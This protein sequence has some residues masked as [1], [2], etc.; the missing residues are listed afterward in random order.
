MELKETRVLT[1]IQ[2]QPTVF[3]ECILLSPKARM[4]A[5]DPKNTDLHIRRERNDQMLTSYTYMSRFAERAICEQCICIA[6]RMFGKQVSGARGEDR[7]MHARGGSEFINS[8]P[9]HSPLHHPTI[10][11]PPSYL[12]LSSPV[13]TDSWLNHRHV[14]HHQ[15]AECRRGAL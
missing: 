14:F 5:K 2:R 4:F 11:S 8:L 13:S 7:D 6:Y 3:V 10:I 1:N 9:S 12:R 15:H